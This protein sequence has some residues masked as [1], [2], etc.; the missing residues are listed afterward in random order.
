MRINTASKSP[1]SPGAYTVGLIGC[2]SQKLKRAAPARELYVSQLFKKASAYEP[3]DMG[4]GH[5]TSPPI[6]QWCNMVQ[7]QLEVEFSGLENVQLVVLAGEQ[8]RYAVYGGRWLNEIPMKGLGIGQQLG[9]L[10]AELPADGRSTVRA[11]IS[12][13]AKEPRPEPLATIG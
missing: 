3:Y 12:A 1:T 13:A 4:L 11:G 8:Y 7:A 6:H 5:R 10:T 2:A 9:W